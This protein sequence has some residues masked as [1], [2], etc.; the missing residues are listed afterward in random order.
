[1]WQ[2]YCSNEKWESSYNDTS[3]NLSDVSPCNYEEADT[4]TLLHTLHQIR[5]KSRK[6]CISAV[7]TDVIVIALSKLYELSAVAL[8]EP[9]VEFGVSVNG[10]R[11]A[12]HWLAYSLSPSKCGAFPSFYALTRWDTVS[13]FLGKGNKSAWETWK[14]YPEATEIFLALS[15]PVDGVLSDN[16]I[17]AIEI[18]I[19]LIVA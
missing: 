16:S 17:S 13:S 1:M 19:C 12:V 11:I 8:E 4:R 3:I 14:C 6:V 7:D 2:D 15:S 9:W 5:N 18:F 10:K